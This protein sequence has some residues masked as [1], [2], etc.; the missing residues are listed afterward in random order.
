M[1]EYNTSQF[2]PTCDQRLQAVSNREKHCSKC[3]TTWNRDIVGALNQLK[4]WTHWLEYGERPLH[5][6]RPAATGAE[7][8]A[9]KPSKKRGVTTAGLDV[10][11]P[12][13]AGPRQPCRPPT[14]PQ[15]Q[16]VYPVGVCVC[17]Q[18]CVWP[19]E[20]PSPSSCLS[21][22]LPLRHPQCCCPPVLSRGMSRAW[23]P[24]PVSPA[25][26]A[27]PAW[28]QGPWSLAIHPGPLGYSPPLSCPVP[29]P[30]PGAAPS[31]SPVSPQSAGAGLSTRVKVPCR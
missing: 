25:S 21:C 16:G 17:V 12:R 7:G 6:R 4:V 14:L 2:C 8:A 23:P 11:P 18:H 27:S 3:S 29:Y 28:R 22:T 24:C 19:R 30:G 5:L 20:R 10:D 15:D 31:A 26:P 9:A 1:D 13:G